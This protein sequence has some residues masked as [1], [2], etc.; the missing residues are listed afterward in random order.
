MS[1][2]LLSRSGFALVFLAVVAG[3]SSTEPESAGFASSA[4]DSE[5]RNN[6]RACLYEGSYESG[7]R[8]YAE[9]QARRLNQAQTARLR[10][11]GR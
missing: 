4:V 10:R 8:G 7:E 6:R 9:E 2:Q 1:M 5:C 11:M 3:C